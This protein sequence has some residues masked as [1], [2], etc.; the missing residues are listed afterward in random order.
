MDETIR[1]DV[2]AREYHYDEDDNAKIF[3]K[4]IRRTINP[5]HTSRI[6]YDDRYQ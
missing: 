2:L 6:R 1:S 3:K 5:H 4:L